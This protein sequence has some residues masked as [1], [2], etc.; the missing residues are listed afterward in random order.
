MASQTSQVS[1]MY[2]K[3]KK[4]VWGINLNNSREL[5]E[6]LYKLHNSNPKKGADNNDFKKDCL[7]CKDIPDA[8]C[9]TCGRGMPLF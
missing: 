9:R 6:E 8:K 7:E 3:N 1:R 4:P 5:T 2:D